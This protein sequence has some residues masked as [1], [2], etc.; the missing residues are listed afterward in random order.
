MSAVSAAAADEME[1]HLR[2]PGCIAFVRARDAVLG[3]A[4]KRPLRS[5][6]N[7]RLQHRLGEVVD[8]V[9]SAGHIARRSLRMLAR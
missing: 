6:F 8:G 9:L 3:I 1:K 4:R 5:Y 2:G 7:D